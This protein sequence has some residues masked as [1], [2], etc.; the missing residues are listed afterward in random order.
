MFINNIQREREVMS[1]VTAGQKL[2]EKFLML[3][4]NGESQLTVMAAEKDNNKM[5]VIGL[6]T[7]EG[8]FTPLAR[9]LSQRDL[10]GMT[11]LWEPSERLATA[12]K[13]AAN[14]ERGKLPGDF[15]T[16]RQNPLFN[17]EALRLMR[18]D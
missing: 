18:L 10:D 1:T 14:T 4:R 9:L 6:S 15:G 3:A 7:A 8:N 2:F 17:D 13:T 11:P 12:F 16:G 5:V